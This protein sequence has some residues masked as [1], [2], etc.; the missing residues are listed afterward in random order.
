MTDEEE[1][2]QD[3]PIEPPDEAPSARDSPPAQNVEPSGKT[4]VKGI[5]DGHTG[6]GV[7]EGVKG[8]PPDAGIEGKSGQDG[9]TKPV[10]VARWSARRHEQS[11][12]NADGVDQP[13]TTVHE[14]VLD[15]PTDPPPPPELP[16]ESP[17]Q[18]EDEAHAEREGEWSQ[19]IG[20]ED[21]RSSIETATSDAAYGI[22]DQNDLQNGSEQ[23]ARTPGRSAR[24]K[25]DPGQ[26]DHDG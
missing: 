24:T 18:L 17:Q 6:A 9:H 11:M 16:D 14:N 2:Q 13:N 7:D 15:V 21:V 1:H 10:E 12:K 19:C 26:V 5:P 22:D 8:N 25:W 20:V 4:A 23:V 3:S